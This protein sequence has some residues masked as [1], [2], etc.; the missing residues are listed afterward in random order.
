M[1]AEYHHLQAGPSS[2]SLWPCATRRRKR[3]EGDDLSPAAVAMDLDAEAERAADKLKAVSQELGHEIRVFSSTTFAAVP[4]NL[5][6]AKHEED[7]DF[8]ELKPADYF[9]LISNRMA[10]QSKMLQTRKMREAELAAQRAKITK[11]VMRVRFPD[12]YILEADFLPSERIHS[13]VDLL[14]KVLARPELPFYLY[15]V[16]P[17]KR[18]PDTS[19]DF[20]TVGFVPGAN[21]Y[22]SYD[23]LPEGSELSP[24]DVKSGPYLCEEIRSLDGLSLLSK[25]ASQSDY[26]RMNS[27]AHQSDASQSDPAPAA[28]KKPNRPKWFKR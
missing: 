6:S 14:V 4:N 11:A 1:E 17:K 24:D 5:P 18:I 25:P 23:D 19:Q 3:A 7:D 9:N 12:G 16:P 21:V 22:F 28:N 20:Y 10:E 26:S 27:S 8:Y 15:T 13:L 2:A